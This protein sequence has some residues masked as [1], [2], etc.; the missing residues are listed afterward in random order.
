MSDRRKDHPKHP[1]RRQHRQHAER[2]HAEQRED[3]RRLTNR[4]SHSP[5]AAEMWRLEGRHAKETLLPTEKLHA[6]PP[7]AWTHANYGGHPCVVGPF[8]SLEQAKAFN[9][10]PQ[11]QRHY[12][13][14]FFQ[15]RS[16]RECWF[17]EVTS[18][19]QTTLI[20]CPE[21]ASEVVYA[22]VSSSA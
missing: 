9:Q 11:Q 4:S 13:S 7:D 3:E 17:V 12:E 1:D 8:S 16:A 22:E 21:L 19:G 2:T 5:N 20:S 14:Y 10:K 6:V 18:D 15:L